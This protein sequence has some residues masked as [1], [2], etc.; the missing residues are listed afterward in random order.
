MTD[1][2]Q[3]VTDALK[4]GTTDRRLVVDAVAGGIEKECLY[5]PGLFVTMLPAAAFQ[6]RFARALIAFGERA[7]AEDSPN[8]YAT[9]E[10]DSRLDPVL[11]VDGVIVTMRGIYG[12][13]GEEVAY[14]REVGLQILTDPGN[15]DV[16]SWISNEAR[17]LAEYYS[18]RLEDEAGNS[19]PDS[20]GSSAGVGASKKTSK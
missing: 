5:R 12:A 7:A 4:L 1:T 10:V 17:Q 13:D 8:D 6:K 9:Y 3:A 18:D 16:L 14:T 15:A 11:V 20:S 19:S 2:S